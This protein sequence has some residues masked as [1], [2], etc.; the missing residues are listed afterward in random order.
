MDVTEMDKYVTGLQKIYNLSAFTGQSEV[1]I[2]AYVNSETLLDDFNTQ[3][4][5]LRKAAGD[6]PITTTMIQKLVT[7]G[8]VQQSVLD[9]IKSDQTYFDSL[10]KEQKLTYVQAITVSANLEGDQAVKSLFESWQLQ[11]GGKKNP[12]GTIVGGGTFAEYLAQAIGKPVTDGGIDDTG[13]TNKKITG[14]NGGGG[15]KTNPLDGI[16]KSLQNVRKASIDALGGTKELFKLF[17][18]GKNISV[19]K[20]I[21]NQL[22]TLTSNTDF[23]SFIAGLDKKE[24][25]L[26]ITVKKGNVELTNRGRLLEKAYRAKTVGD[27]VLS[28]QKLS[29]A[30]KDELTAR[31]LLIKAGYSYVEAVELSRDA[32]VAAAYASAAATKG[33]ANRKK[34][35]EDVDNALKKGLAAQKA[36]LTA[37][38]KF[39]ELYNKIQGKLDADKTAIELKFKI[40]TAADDK[41]IRDAENKI[42][43]I[44]YKLDDQEAGLTLISDK[45]EVI[46]EKY[47]KRLEA[48]DKIKAVND[49]IA[50]QQKNQLS[51]ADALSSGDIGAAASAMQQIQQQ[52]VSDSSAQQEDLIEK[53]RQQ[54]LLRVSVL[55]NGELKT[56][57]QIEKTIKDLQK[58]IFEIEEGRLEPALENNRILIAARDEALLKLDQESDKWLAVQTSIEKAKFATLDYAQ[59]LKDANALAV[60]AVKQIESGNPVAEPATPAITPAANTP[61]ANTPPKEKA[62]NLADMARRV[63]RGEYGNGQARIKKL[64][65]EG[66]TKAQVNKIQDEVNRRYYATGGMVKGYAAGGMIGKYMAGG[67]FPGM[68]K[69]GTDTIPAML[70]PGEFVIRK[71]A[72]QNFGVDNLESIN[73]GKSLRDSVYNYSVNVN[74]KTD[75]DASQIAK[76]VMTQIKQ[77]DSQRIRGVGLR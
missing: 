32:D 76:T 1:I 51:L 30:S 75:A 77:I 66:Y 33:L 23:A 69:R 58:E 40:D 61:A 10:P 62:L 64:M 22:L 70:T 73:S 68:P 44:Q 17:E 19:F 28:Q 34:A 71:Q 9:A 47:D 11:N 7:E 72:V 13:G 2:N 46:N 29:V 27:F 60:S 6:K 31:N 14:N 63:Y 3:M 54:E 38:E 26:F 16:L 43:G 50:Q 53:A 48:L 37:E 20:G 52:F 18:K 45:E 36:T 42:A 12:F 59:A 41:I 25:G 74:V 56:R 5:A 49:N 8:T 65:A 35:I 67:G 15:R 4:D 55:I 39:D 21:E 57:E 24:Q